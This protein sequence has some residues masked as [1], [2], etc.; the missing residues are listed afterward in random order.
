VFRTPAWLNPPALAIRRQR[1]QREI[2]AEVFSNLRGR[3]HRIGDDECSELVDARVNASRAMRGGVGRSACHVASSTRRPL[4]TSSIVASSSRTVTDSPPRRKRTRLPAAQRG[5][6]GAGSDRDGL[7]GVA[8]SG[9]RSGW[10]AASLP[11]ATP[12]YRLGCARV[13]VI[14]RMEEEDTG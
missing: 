9:C 5:S 4:R 10:T 13:G 1:H 7:R 12:R 8:R 11:P 2:T 3:A 6:A 14:H